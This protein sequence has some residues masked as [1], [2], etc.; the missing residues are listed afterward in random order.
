LVAVAGIAVVAVAVACGGSTTSDVPSATEAAGTST[1]TAAPTMAA[2]TAPTSAATAEATAG[3]SQFEIG[4]EIFNKTAG[5]VG[6]AY[7]HGSD[8]K[9]D[10]PSMLGAP[11]NRGA[12][13]EMVRNALASFPDMS[14]IKL[15]NDEIKAVVVYLAYLAEQP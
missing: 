10:G 14:F 4:R 5:G 6:C 3:S 11:P 7:C 1:A 15:T 13:E 12:T 9:G 8:G 2:T